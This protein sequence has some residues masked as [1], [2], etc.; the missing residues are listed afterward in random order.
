[1]R[2]L[3]KHLYIPKATVFRVLKTL[4]RRGYVYSPSKGTFILGA[5]LISLGSGVL[6][7]FD[8]KQVANPR[9]GSSYQFNQSIQS[10]RNR[11]DFFDKTNSPI[12]RFND[13]FH[14]SL[15]HSLP[16]CLSIPWYENAVIRYFV[17]N[18]P[19]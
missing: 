4:E 11:D 19:G 5:E 3:S 7:Q 2:E 8:L 17:A 1:M 14:H 18:I 9:K 10:I 15:H 16:N 13:L 6:D 12:K